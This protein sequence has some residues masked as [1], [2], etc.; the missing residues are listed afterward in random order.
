MK[1]VDTVELLKSYSVCKKFVQAQ[2]YA[3]TY[4]DPTGTQKIAKK[5]QYETRMHVIES[6]IQLLEPSD[7]YTL[8]HLHYINGVPIDKCAECMFI[9]RSTAFRMLSKAHKSLC[10]LVSKKGADNE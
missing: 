7:E 6:L 2:E 8:L 1:E 4:F 10:D 3:K 5:E 9:S